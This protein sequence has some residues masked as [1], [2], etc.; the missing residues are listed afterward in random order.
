MVA[1]VFMVAL[2]SFVHTPMGLGPPFFCTAPKTW[3]L[4]AS[5]APVFALTPQDK[6]CHAWTQLQHP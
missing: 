1:P 4:A 2:L 5:I 6:M 3:A